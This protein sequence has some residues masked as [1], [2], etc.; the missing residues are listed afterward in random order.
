MCGNS[1]IIA[2]NSGKWL[3]GTVYKYVIY[4]FLDSNVS[5]LVG[6]MGFG[7]DIRICGSLIKQNNELQENTTK[8]KTVRCKK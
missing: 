5:D 6:L 2:N 7:R 1:N 4:I 3:H 8:D